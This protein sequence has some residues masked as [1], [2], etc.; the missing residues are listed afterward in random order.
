MSEFLKKVEEIYSTRLKEG[1]RTIP[2]YSWFR[3]RIPEDAEDILEVG[4]NSGD[5]AEWLAEMGYNVLAIDLPKVIK[6]I[7]T[8]NLASYVAQD[9]QEFREDFV[10]EFDCVIM[11]EVIQHLEHPKNAIRNIYEYLRDGGTLL[12]SAIRDGRRDRLAINPF[13]DETLVT[14][15]EEHGFEVQEW[16]THG[17]HIWVYAIK[18]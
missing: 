11:G 13:P 5:S 2:R 8:K 18:K 4:C 14:F 3:E 1:K 12:I 15:L 10:N 6:N 7:E 9:I 17:A 16:K